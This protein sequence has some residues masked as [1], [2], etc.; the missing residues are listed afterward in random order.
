[1]LYF[2]NRRD[3]IFEEKNLEKL[4]ALIQETF[5][6]PVGVEDVEEFIYALNKQEFVIKSMTELKEVL[7]E[8]PCIYKMRDRDGNIKE[9]RGNIKGY[10]QDTISGSIG[11][12]ALIESQNGTVIKV[13]VIKDNIIIP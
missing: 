4:C 13:P 8:R 6:V 5:N 10:F 2:N 9:Y 11:V 1:M 7:T 12:V 3:R